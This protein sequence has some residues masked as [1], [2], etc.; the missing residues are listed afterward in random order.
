[1][2]EVYKLT[3]EAERVDCH[4]GNTVYDTS[5]HYIAAYSSKQA[6]SHVCSMMENAGWKINSVTTVNIYTNDIRDKCDQIT[7]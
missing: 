1:M 3:V 4:T 7:Y 6:N 2:F 5:E